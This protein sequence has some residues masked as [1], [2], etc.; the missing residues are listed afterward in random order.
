MFLTVIREADNMGVVKYRTVKNIKG[1][2]GKNF[3]TFGGEQRYLNKNHLGLSVKR[4]L[5]PS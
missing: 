3:P 5:A 4:G 2:W 1:A